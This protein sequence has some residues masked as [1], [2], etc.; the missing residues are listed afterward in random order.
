MF[1]PEIKTKIEEELTRGAQARQEGYEGRAR[2]CARRA[3]GIAIRAYLEGIGKPVPAQSAYDLLRYLEAETG[4]PLEIRKA[5]EHLLARVNE[6][7]SLPEE[8]DLLAE[9]RWMI[10]RLEAL[11]SH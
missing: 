4:I 11:N 3:A 9:A 7:F 2:V 10:D 6:N 1:R 5:A 8:I